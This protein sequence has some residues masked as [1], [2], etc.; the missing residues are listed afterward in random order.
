MS[1][2]RVEF[3]LPSQGLPVSLADLAEAYSRTTSDFR[4]LDEFFTRRIAHEVL[5]PIDKQAVLVAPADSVIQ[6]A[7]SLS[8]NEGRRI[9][10]AFVP[11]V[12]R[13]LRRCSGVP[14]SSAARL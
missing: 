3:S 11:Q 9:T 8:P 2:L 14:S 6:N 12:T 7:F 10:E 4:T 1:D 13:K 5:R